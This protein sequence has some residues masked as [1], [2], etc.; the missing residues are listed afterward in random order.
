MTNKLQSPDTGEMSGWAVL[1]RR[2]ALDY[3]ITA[4]LPGPLK[5]LLSGALTALT[6]V[7]PTATGGTPLWTSSVLRALLYMLLTL[8]AGLW[9][10]ARGDPA[11][12]LAGAL[13][14]VSAMRNFTS[15][16]GHH[17][18]HSTAQLPFSARWTRGGYNVLSALLLLPSFEAYR[19]DHGVHHGKVAGAE[20]PDQQ[21]IEYLQTKLTGWGAFLRTVFDPRFHARFLIAR[22]RASIGSGPVW[23]RMLA[24][25][26]ILVVAALPGT[27]AAPWLLALTLGYQTASIMSWLSLHLWGARPESGRPAEIATAVTFGRLLIPEASFRGA[28]MLPVYALA[29]ALWLQGDL[30]NHDLHHLGKGPWT[31][32]PYVRTRLLLADTP[33]RQTVTV[34][35]MFRVAFDAAGKK[36]ARRAEMSDG[37]MLEM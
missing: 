17:L 36:P 37:S 12:K 24:V 33:L 31:D 14:V 26:G 25:T 21:F 32:A 34:R 8:G 20:D 18:T 13:A 16:V 3:F 7:A 15:G 23:R 28:A 10:I 9:M 22:L 6:G 5:T 27:A 29:R 11:A 19:K 30:V 4:G 1:R 2:D 35:D